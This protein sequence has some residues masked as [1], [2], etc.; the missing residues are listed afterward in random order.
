MAIVHQRFP[1]PG[2]QEVR[3]RIDP[4]WHLWIHLASADAKIL[5]SGLSI[6]GL[7]EA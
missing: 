3:M 6:V 4:V 2:R 7:T 1:I 5:D